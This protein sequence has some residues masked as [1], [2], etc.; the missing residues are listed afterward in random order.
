MART[1]I[2]LLAFA[3][4]GATLAVYRR[5]LPEVE[6]V[7]LERDRRVQLA[8]ATTSETAGAFVM[9]RFSPSGQRLV[10][11][12]GALLQAWSLT[13]PETPLRVP[14]HEGRDAAFLDEQTLAVLG[15]EPEIGRE[16]RVERR[17]G[18]AVDARN[19]KTH[20]AAFGVPASFFA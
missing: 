3:P 10:V 20:E 17:G 8:G 5:G 19:G 6:V 14:G 16:V 7:D 11:L 15:E 18:G 13:Q 2:L 12:D 4:V 1:L 9:S